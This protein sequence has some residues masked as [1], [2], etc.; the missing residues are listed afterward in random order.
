VLFA[1]VGGLSLAGAMSLNVLER[2][3][4]IGILRA[5]G[6]PGRVVMQI[7]I[8]EGLVIGVVSWLI[9]SLLAFPMAKVMTVMVGISFIKV[10]LDFRFAPIGIGLWLI[11]VLILSFVASYLPANN[12]T[13][14]VVREALVYE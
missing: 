1:T 14:V 4:E 11:I 3:K 12:A 10:P 5:V 6:A 13:R 2:T 7:V 8:I 9:A